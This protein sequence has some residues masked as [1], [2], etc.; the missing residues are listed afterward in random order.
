MG[1]WPGDGHRG[2]GGDGDSARFHIDAAAEHL[3]ERGG[4][5]LP[6]TS[7][8]D[9]GLAGGEHAALRL[10]HIAVTR[11]ADLVAAGRHLQ[12]IGLRALGDKRGFEL[13]RDRDLRRKLVGDFAKRELH[14]LL[15]FSHG[16]HLAGAGHVGIA[17]GA[18]AIEERHRDHRLK[19][20]GAAAEK[21]GQRRA[22]KAERGGQHDAGEESGTGRVHIGVGG[23]EALLRRQHIGP[24]QQDAAGQARRQGHAGLL[25]RERVA[26]RQVIRHAPHQ[27]V[28]L[29]DGHA[30]LVIELGQR[31]LGGFELGQC[32]LALFFVGTADVAAIGRDL[33]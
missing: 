33:E 6:G 22:G 20:P 1:Y 4:R 28:E 8:F 32:V 12:P 27:K 18:A 3:V 11:V 16:D 19:R 29:V 30:V 9:G 17:R 23:G 2:A 10:Q 15:V 31:G 7:Q 21:A 25:L 26:R 13:R 5:I 14:R 24:V